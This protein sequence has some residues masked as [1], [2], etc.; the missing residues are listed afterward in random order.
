LDAECG[1]SYSACIDGA[2]ACFEGF[3]ADGD[4]CTSSEFRCPNSGQP[5]LAAGV[6]QKCKLTDDDSTFSRG[7]CPASYICFAYDDSFDIN[8]NPIGHCC[9]NTS[10]GDY[11]PVCAVGVRHF[12][13]VCAESTDADIPCPPETHQC[14]DGACC[15]R[16]CRQ[17]EEHVNV[18]GKCF[19]EADSG[20]PCENAGQCAE[21]AQCKAG[22]D[23]QKVCTTA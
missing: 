20:G 10:S 7:D 8:G 6:A 13:A 2:C 19:L 11:K 3:K 4:K 17:S 16:P 5:L 9:Q 21:K 15:Q 18:D 23:G 14:S 1:T 22:A 12:K